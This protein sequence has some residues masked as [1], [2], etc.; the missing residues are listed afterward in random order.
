MNQAERTEELE[1][2]AE[3]SYDQLIGEWLDW[4]DTARKYERKIPAID[5]LDYR[6]DC[7]LELHRARQ[8]DC[9]PL[10]KLRAYRIAS[11]MVAQYWREVNKPT[12]RVCIYS[13][14]PKERHCKECEWKP[15]R[16]QVC[17]WT[18]RLPVQSLDSEVE[19]TEGNKV[20]LLDTVATE[21]IHDM[22]EA[23]T[24]LNTWLLGCPTRLIEIAEKRR[25]GEALS[26]KDRKYL[27]RYREQEQKS[28]F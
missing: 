14:V 17:P 6:H 12:T 27:Q 22:P 23:W 19:D 15:S 25:D 4:L 28:L 24:E 10:P 20:A 11:L 2:L 26:A 8:R 21:D 16:G 18:A 9:K 1:A 7:L 13:G 5:R 3:Q